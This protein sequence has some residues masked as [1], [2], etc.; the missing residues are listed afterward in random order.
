MLLVAVFLRVFGDWG[1]RKRVFCTNYTL[2]AKK[3]DIK[4]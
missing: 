4:K 2:V 1:V 3:I